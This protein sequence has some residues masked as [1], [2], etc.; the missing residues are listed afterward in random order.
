MVAESCIAMF[1]LRMRV[2]MSAIGSV[3]VIG[4]PPSPRRLGHAGDLARVRQLAEADP[5]EAELAVHGTSPA[6]PT[7]PRVLADLE[8]RLGLLLVDECLLRH[9]PAPELRRGGTGTRGSAGARGPRRRS[10]RTCRS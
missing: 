10:G 6:A 4:S 3:I 8:L 5:A 7:A 1:A 9:P 2:S